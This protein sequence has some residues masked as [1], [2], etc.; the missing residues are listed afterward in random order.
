MK[1]KSNPINILSLQKQRS[2]SN[3][4]LPYTGLCQ[5]IFLQKWQILLDGSHFSK[6]HWHAGKN[7]LTP[8]ISSSEKVLCPELQNPLIHGHPS[9]SDS[10][11]SPYETGEVIRRQ[12]SSWASQNSFYLSSVG[13]QPE[14]NWLF[15]LIYQ[16]L[17]G[18]ALIHLSIKLRS[19]YLPET[20]KAE[21]QITGYDGF[22]GVVASQLRC[23]APGFHELDW[24]HQHPT[25]AM[26]LTADPTDY[27]STIKWAK[28][29]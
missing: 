7:L 21:I 12:K 3:G 16:W 24:I 26:D 2:Q 27:R 10:F 15:N 14:R 17:F 19:I 22:Q 9:G 28:I 29:N 6:G 11:Q 4:K 25:Q 20:R 5:L 13:I 18:S 23:N 1:Y 8:F